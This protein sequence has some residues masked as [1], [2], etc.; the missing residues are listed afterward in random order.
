[1][2][3]INADE[4]AQK[5][6]PEQQL[7]TKNGEITM[8]IIRTQIANATRVLKFNDEAEA[9]A[10]E[11]AIAEQT[12]HMA[13]Q[14]AE[15]QETR[16]KA[17]ASLAELEERL[18]VA[19][20]KI[21]ELSSP[22]SQAELM[23]AAIRQE[24]AE[25]AIM[26]SLRTKNAKNAKDDAD[27]DDEKTENADD[28]DDEKTENADEDDSGGEGTDDGATENSDDETDDEKAEN[29][30]DD[31]D[32]TENS[33]DDEADEDFTENAT[34]SGFRKNA[35]GNAKTLASRRA[36]LVRKVANH[37]GMNIPRNWTQAQYD[38]AFTTLAM[39]AR[40]ANAAKK[41]KNSAKSGH[42]VAAGGTTAKPNSNL[43]SLRD[44][45]LSPMKSLANGNK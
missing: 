28:D 2:R 24:K 32:E 3:I 30:D 34:K 12:A 25:R 29:A 21:T 22:D 40:K 43:L 4:K 1:V 36:A 10:V 39:Q 26:N 5:T 45:M 7:T 6:E 44:R 13:A 33:D 11:N 9:V 38:A 35:L 20:A 19:N 23:E 27:D 15:V 41:V 42:K 14:I 8:V 18:K 31:D 16:D 37:N 17:L